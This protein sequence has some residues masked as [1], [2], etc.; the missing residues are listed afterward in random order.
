M[1]EIVDA[2]FRKHRRVQRACIKAFLPL[3]EFLAVADALRKEKE[4]ATPA[5][6]K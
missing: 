2:R 4:C 5:T 6:P 1:T 3:D